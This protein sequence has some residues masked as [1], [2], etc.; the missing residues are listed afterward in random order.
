[1]YIYLQVSQDELDFD[2]AKGS[3]CL[4]QPIFFGKE[5]QWKHVLRSKSI[6]CYQESNG[7]YVCWKLHWKSY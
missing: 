3:S 2:L 5:S 4:A 1:M 6:P 7:C